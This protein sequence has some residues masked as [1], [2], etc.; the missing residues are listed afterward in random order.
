[1]PEFLDLV[2]IDLAESR[3][4]LFDQP[5]GKTHAEPAGDELEQR[6]AAGRIEPVKPVLDKTGTFASRGG[7]QSLDYFGQSRRVVAASE[8]IALLRPGQCDG[9]G[10]IADIIIGIAK[11][12][13]VHAGGNQLAQLRRLDCRNI[14][15][16]GDGCQRIA[17]LRIR[18]G[19]E[20]ILQ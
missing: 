10:Q 11:Q 1:M 2:D 16:A 6:I 17:P 9:F 13:R 12:L 8:R 3:Q 15:I 20:I 4:R 19:A 7:D 5:A 18:H 14:E